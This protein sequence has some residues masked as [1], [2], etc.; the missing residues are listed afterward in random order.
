MF[1]NPNVRT[2]N[3]IRAPGEEMGPMSI[4]S[5][6]LPPQGFLSGP[7]FSPPCG[8]HSPQSFSHG[9]VHIRLASVRARIGCVLTL[10]FSPSVR[11]SFFNNK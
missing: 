10:V 1:C 2:S 6:E 4:T 11:A 3:F 7:L 5:L 8:L 9:D